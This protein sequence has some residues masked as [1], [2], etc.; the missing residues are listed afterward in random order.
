MSGY[1]N[2]KSLIPTMHNSPGAFAVNASLFI[3][4]LALGFTKK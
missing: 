2:E 4:R 3:G 1:D